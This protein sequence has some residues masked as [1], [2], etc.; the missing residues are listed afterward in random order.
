[1]NRRASPAVTRLVP[2]TAGL[3]R[4]L[5]TKASLRI[6]AERSVVYYADDFLFGREDIQTAAHSSTRSRV[7]GLRTSGYPP[8]AGRYASTRAGQPTGSNR[9]TP[10]AE[11]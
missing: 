10:D 5:I 1:M 7:E 3:R 9:P 8:F 4:I 11:H 6:E 2:I